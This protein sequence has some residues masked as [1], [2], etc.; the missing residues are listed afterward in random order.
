MTTPTTSLKDA[1]VEQS[2]MSEIDSDI[3]VIEVRKTKPSYA[4]S[5]TLRP[6]RKGTSTSTNV[7]K[8]EEVED[9]IKEEVTQVVT[10]SSQGDALVVEG[11]TE[12][13]ENPLVQD[14]GSEIVKDDR[15]EMPEVT[16]SN[17]KK[18]S[19]SCEVIS[20]SGKPLKQR[21]RGRKKAIKKVKNL[22]QHWSI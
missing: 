8:K 17:V 19:S 10:N 12:S 2:L 4:P 14:L 7:A 6:R 18:D 16:L 3:E 15:N 13:G 22:L 20:E 21:G 9:D 11:N 1:L 5:R